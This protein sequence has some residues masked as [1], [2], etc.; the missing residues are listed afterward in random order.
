M[1]VLHTSPTILSSYKHNDPPPVVKRRAKIR[2][3]VFQAMSTPIQR[4]Q[5]FANSI[6]AS[7]GVSQPAVG[8]YVYTHKQWLEWYAEHPLS[9]TDMDAAVWQWKQDVPMNPSTREKI[10][11][12]EEEGARSSNNKLETFATVLL[13]YTFGRRASLSSLPCL[14]SNSLQRR[15]TPCC[16]IGPSI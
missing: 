9:Q 13:W 3:K 15:S 8:R 7:R 2:A 12:W 11:A 1:D 6:A 16:S 10:E 4:R 14:F 5:G